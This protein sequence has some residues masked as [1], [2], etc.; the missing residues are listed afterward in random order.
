MSLAAIIAS[1]QGDEKEYLHHYLGYDTIQEACTALRDFLT[2][3]LS[4]DA[5]Y[6]LFVDLEH[7]EYAQELETVALETIGEKLYVGGI[8]SAIYYLYRHSPFY[9]FGE[10]YEPEE[11]GPEDFDPEDYTLLNNRKEKCE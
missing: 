9:S 7:Q 10:D 1:H 5:R 3:K 8:D 11:P 4:K 6:E 2:D